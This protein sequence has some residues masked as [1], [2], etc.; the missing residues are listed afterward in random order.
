VSNDHFDAAGRG[1]LMRGVPLYVTATPEN[2]DE[3]GYLEANP[4]IAAAVRAGTLESGRLHF[5]VFGAKEGREQISSVLIEAMQA[6]KI[7]RIKPL[8]NLERS[9]VRRGVKYDFLTDELRRETRIV[10]TNEVSRNNYD[11]YVRALIDELENGLILDCGAGSRSTYYPNVINYEIVDYVSTDVIG[12]GES[13]PFKDASF[14]GV[15]SIA[16]LEHVRDPFL[17]AA[18]IARVLKPGGKLVCCVAFLSPVHGYPNHYYNM[19]PQG[20][21]ALFERHL[22]ICDQQV[23]ESILPIW[24]LTW[25]VSSW[26]RGLE[27]KTREQFLSM[28]LR[29]LLANPE[30]L[31]KKPWVASLSTEKNLELAAGS[32]IFGRKRLAET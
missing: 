29:T 22:E 24:S 18:E 1:G 17:C 28:P 6:D 23:I 14:D 4:D 7:E 9:H 26:A 10:D 20:L 32:M 11:G 13:L 21:R 2:F 3:S 30:D 15:I 19:T 25:I 8:L 12:V 31:L 5:E 27:G 16:V